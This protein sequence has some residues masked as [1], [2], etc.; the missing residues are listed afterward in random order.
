MANNEWYI[1]IMI[2]LVMQFYI[3]VAF[4]YRFRIDSD[5][6]ILIMQ[7]SGVLVPRA[8][9][10]KAEVTGISFSALNAEETELLSVMEITSEKLYENG[11]P[12]K[13]GTFLS[14]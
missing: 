1:D 10:H 7:Q 5:I 12:K 4:L 9:Y 3:I 11:E 6:V 8:L 14:I 2:F 13:G